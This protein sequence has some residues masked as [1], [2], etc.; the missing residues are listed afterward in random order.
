MHV[1]MYVWLCEFI[2]TYGCINSFEPIMHGSQESP[3]FS[4]ASQHTLCLK[5]FII[6]ESDV[7]PFVALMKGC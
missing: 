1:Y 5:L 2:A 4:H 6:S 3:A 7:E